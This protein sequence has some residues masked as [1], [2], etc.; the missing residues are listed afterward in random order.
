MG[1]KAI[2]H[3]PISIDAYFLAMDLLKCLLIF[4]LQPHVSLNDAL[5]FTTII[6]DLFL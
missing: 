1:L 6:N 2:S 3:N 5:I 4:A